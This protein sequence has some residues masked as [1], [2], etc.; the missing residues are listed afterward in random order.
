MPL[1]CGDH[2]SLDG[3]WSAGMTDPSPDR[4]YE[5]IRAD[6]RATDEISFKLMGP[7]PLASGAAFLVRG[8]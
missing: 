8:V 2:H 6:I 4:L 3:Y 1:F 5:D 7:V